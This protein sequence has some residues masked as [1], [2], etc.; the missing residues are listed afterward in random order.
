MLRHHERVDGKG[1]P[2]HLTGNQIPIAARIIQICDAWLAMTS[3]HSYQLPIPLDEAAQKLRDN[4]GTQFDEQ[5][6]ARFL[7]SRTEIGA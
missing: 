2:S 6:V 1:Y 4:A 3:N 5:L 7:K